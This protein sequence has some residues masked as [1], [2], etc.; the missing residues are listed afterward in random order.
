MPWPPVE[1][2]LRLG[3]AGALV[4]LVARAAAPAAAA[5]P[6]AAT[7]GTAGVAATLAPAAP[8]AAA[9]AADGR[10]PRSASWGRFDL[11]AAGLT[12]AQARPVTPPVSSGQP[13]PGARPPASVLGS[14]WL[15]AGL[16]LATGAGLLARWS[17]DR[18]DRAYGGY[19]RAASRR[20][21]QRAFDRAERYDR[22]TGSAYLAMH[23][24]M[25][26]TV[27]VLLF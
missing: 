5:G 7:P 6:S 24:G 12:P 25:A 4:A 11:V 13:T 9:T 14:G 16:G 18:A 8:P 1:R 17:E 22:V 23:A 3:V 15:Y 19:L 27:C 21:Q 26:L 2:R 20:R 10:G